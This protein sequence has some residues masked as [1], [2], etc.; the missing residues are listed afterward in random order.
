MMPVQLDWL[1][2]VNA[3]F[4]DTGIV[5]TEDERV[6]VSSFSYLEQT[7]LL[8]NSTQPRVVGE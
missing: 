6:I 1:S 8:L 5:I 2:Y 4:N 7:L 3:V